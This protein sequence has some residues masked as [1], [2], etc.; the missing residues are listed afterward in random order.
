MSVS[1]EPKY[2]MLFGSVMKEMMCWMIENKQELAERMVEKL[3]AV[4]WR[5][6]LTHEEAM[7]IVKGMMPPAAWQ[8]DEW[9]RTMQE[10]EL[11]CERESVFNG[12]ALWV[13]MNATHS[14][15]G[16]VIASLMGIA[17]KDAPSDTDY[18]KA[19]HS[20]AMNLLLDKDGKYNVRS[21]FL[22]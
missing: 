6:Y 9:H 12:Y 3:C 16:N 19:V 20:M 8:Y 14:D 2:M 18:I 4:K 1:N 10:H 11:E 7:E 13:V 15:N 22:D 5:Q 21:Y 17:F